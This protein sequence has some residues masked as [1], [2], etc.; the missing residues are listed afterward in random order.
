[1]YKILFDKNMSDFLTKI[2]NKIISGG[3]VNKS[4]ENVEK[5]YIKTTDEEYVVGESI[6]NY[7]SDR[8]MD[9]INV[10]EIL[11]GAKTND[12][13][14]STDI[15]TIIKKKKTNLYPYLKKTGT[16]KNVKYIT[17]VANILKYIIDKSEMGDILMKKVA[18]LVD[19]L[20]QIEEAKVEEIRKNI[21][22]KTETKYINIPILEL[23]CGNFQ[24]SKYQPEELCKLVN[25]LIDYINTNNTNNTNN[26]N[27]V[28]KFAHIECKITLPKNE[29]L[30]FSKETYEKPE[31]IFE[32][33]EL[34][35]IK[36]AKQIE[37]WHIKVMK[38][39]DE[40]L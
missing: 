39:I 13:D 11:G 28:S 3:F 12:S 17:T 2:N 4:D 26:A 31:D 16:G 19:K 37:L 35:L 5:Q 9:M 38:K 6:N 14:K 33:L 15:Q 1:M 27:K 36:V 20:T 25:C 30:T 34:P 10:K 24:A 22:C 18:D 40:L 7:Y 21:V 29:V 32:Q 8:I 23:N